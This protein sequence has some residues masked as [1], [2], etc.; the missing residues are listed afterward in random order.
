L[1]VLEG[2]PTFAHAYSNQD[3]EKYPGQKRFKTR[4]AEGE[5]LAP[6]K[7]TVL[8]DFTYDCGGIGIAFNKRHHQLPNACGRHQVHGP[9]FF[10]TS[11]QQHCLSEQALLGRKLRK[12]H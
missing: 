1:L 10:T 6:G 12:S 11:Q 2:K 8:F 5:K 9:I 7:H 4:L 3:G